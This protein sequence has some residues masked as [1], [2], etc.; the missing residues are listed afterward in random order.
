M[1]REKVENKYDGCQL[2][3]YGL[4]IYKNMMHIPNISK[5]RIIIMDESI[6]DHILAIQASKKRL[7]LPK[8][9]CYSKEA[10]FFAMLK[11]DVSKYIVRCVECLRVKDEH[12]HPTGLLQPLI[13]AK[14]KWE[15]IIKDLIIRLPITVKT[16]HSIALTL[17]HSFLLC[18]LKRN[19]EQVWHQL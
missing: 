14:W 4:L 9:N 5:L 16:F 17:S 3:N 6:R 1:L 10:I 8:N 13:L 7:L 11:R 18:E 12:Q 19:H 2:S 15:V